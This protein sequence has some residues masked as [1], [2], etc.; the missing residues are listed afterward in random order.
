MFADTLADLAAADFLLGS[1]AADAARVLLARA[2][3]LIEEM[4]PVFAAAGVLPAGVLRAFPAAGVTA[5]NGAA[6]AISM[7]NTSASCA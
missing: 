6:A 5:G 4:F 1:V 7:P 3:A 2:A